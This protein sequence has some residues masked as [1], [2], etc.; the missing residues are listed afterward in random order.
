MRDLFTEPE[1]LSGLVSSHFPVAGVVED[2]GRVAFVVLVPPDGRE[3]FLALRRRL[4]PLGLLPMLRERDGR[5]LLVLLPRPPRTPW[6]WA[7]NAAL[8]AATILT[9]FLAGYLMARPLVEAGYLS[10]AASGG[11]SFAAA[12]MAILVTHEM[13]HKV[14][15][16][17][18]GVD[19][20]LPYFIP[21][22][23]PL[24]TMGAVIITRTPAPN[25]DA[26]IDVGAAGPIAGFAVA[27]PVLII[28]ITHSFVIRPTDFSGITLPDPLLLQWLIRWLLHPPSD[29]VVLG[30]PILFAGWI[31]L[32]VTSLNL[33]PAGMLDGGHAVRALLGRRGHQVLSWAAV[34]VAVLLGYW[35]MAVL[36]FLMIPRGHPG[37][38]DDVSPVRPSRWVMGLALLAIFAV[39]VVPSE[40]SPLGRWWR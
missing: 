36:I 37:P 6:R 30:H 25:R 1:R 29:A 14:A 28:G 33:L 26:L 22:F 34:G 5:V 8:F 16:V 20:S 11:A 19:S 18:R 12:L 7:P 2:G 13:G 3:R 23:P 10:S 35:V 32:L 17:L 15:S 31:G 40:A 27:V 21:M 4:E 9:T 38:L 39:S 24:G